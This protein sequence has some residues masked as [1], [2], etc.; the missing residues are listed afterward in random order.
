MEAIQQ[1][2][3][4]A[5][6]SRANGQLVV[7]DDVYELEEAT[8]RTSQVGHYD[9]V[10]EVMLRWSDMHSLDLHNSREQARGHWRTSL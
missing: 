10:F 5:S 1:G 3:E 8:R 9:M 4:L 2:E 7:E 6:K